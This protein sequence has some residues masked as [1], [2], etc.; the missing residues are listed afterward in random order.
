MLIAVGNSDVVVSILQ[1]TSR[2]RQVEVHDIH[3]SFAPTMRV[4]ELKS[5]L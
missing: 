3:P 4:Y 2:P 1:P 5:R